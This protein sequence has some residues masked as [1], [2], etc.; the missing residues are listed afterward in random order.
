VNA[1]GDFRNEPLT[2][3]RSA[4]ARDAM[5]GELIALDGELPLRIPILIGAERLE[6]DGFESIDPSRIDRVVGVAAGATATDADRAVEVAAG[7]AE[8]WGRLPVEDRAAI[9]VR[10]AGLLR[11]DRR[12]VGPR[13]VRA[14]G[15]ATP[16]AGAD[17]GEGVE[18]VVG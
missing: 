6:G 14:C 7:A 1:V 11:R 13:P 17:G 15:Q 5:V 12:R 16:G 9:L 18:I 10:A 8:E 2:E 4:S 3:L